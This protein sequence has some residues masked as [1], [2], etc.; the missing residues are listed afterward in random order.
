[1]EER[2]TKRVRGETG[3]ENG[4]WG[5][6]QGVLQHM[7]EAVERSI[8]IFRASNKQENGRNGENGAGGTRGQDTQY[9]Q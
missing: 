9:I 1:M 2:P 5:I 3:K 6:I 7:V 8:A 4:V